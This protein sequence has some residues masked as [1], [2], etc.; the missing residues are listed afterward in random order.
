[1]EFFSKRNLRKQILIMFSEENCFSRFLI[2]IISP[3]FSFKPQFISCNCQH[4]FLYIV[5]CIQSWFRQ[6]VNWMRTGMISGSERRSSGERAS[7][8]VVDRRQGHEE[9][10]LASAGC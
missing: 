9:G 2:C 5:A 3:L 6:Q 1:M 7:A 8:S 10:R 4:S